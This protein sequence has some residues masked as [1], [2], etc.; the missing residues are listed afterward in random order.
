MKSVF[1]F[2]L[3]IRTRLEWG[4]DRFQQ[5]RVDVRQSKVATYYDKKVR[6]DE[7]VVGQSVYVFAPR[8]KY[9]KL[10]FKWCGPYKN[11][12]CAHPVYSVAMDKGPR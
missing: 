3:R 5:P 1:R 8:N 9:K 12:K 7:L 10:T 11:L 2:N 6:D 4:L